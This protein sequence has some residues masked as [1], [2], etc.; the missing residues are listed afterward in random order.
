M[1]KTSLLHLS[2]VPFTKPR[3]GHGWSLND[4]RAAGGCLAGRGR[5]LRGA[6][7][8]PPPSLRPGSTQ[9]LNSRPREQGQGWLQAPQLPS[10]GAEAVETD[11]QEAVWPWARSFIHS[12][13]SEFLLLPSPTPPVSAPL[14]VQCRVAQ[15]HHLLRQGCSCL[16]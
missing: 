14:Q 2:S 1:V 16:T 5:G 3:D 13:V 12:A 4:L 8:P 11:L 10:Q 7:S 15:C 6:Q 9:C